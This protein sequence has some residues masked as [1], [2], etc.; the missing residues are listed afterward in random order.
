[1]SEAARER[2]SLSGSGIFVVKT[3][4]R[5]TVWDN[6]IQ[7]ILTR[8]GHY[9][10]LT[11]F[12]WDGSQRGEREARE[13]RGCL[14]KHVELPRSMDVTR[15]G[16]R[17]GWLPGGRSTTPVDSR[18]LLAPR[19]QTRQHKYSQ[20]EQEENTRGWGALN[21]CS[22]ERRALPPDTEPEPCGPVTAQDKL[23]CCVKL[24]CL[25][26][27]NNAVYWFLQGFQTKCM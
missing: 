2:P 16:V 18:A 23:T 14:Q 11:S 3:V 15:V 21:Y 25:I 8:S 4:A 20:C 22:V 19:R 5:Q 1:M 27:F 12:C 9:A 10:G 13:D 7:R 24:I 26:S 17:D 6:L